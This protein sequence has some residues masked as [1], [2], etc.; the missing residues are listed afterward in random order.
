MMVILFDLDGVLLQPHAY[1]QALRDTVDF[2]G[3]AIGYRSVVLTKDDIELFESVGV[4]T[5]W[6]SSAICAALLLR[7]MWSIHPERRLPSAPPLPPAP[8]HDISAPQFQDFFRSLE[9]SLAADTSPVVAAERALLNDGFAYTDLQAFA[10][11]NILRGAHKPHGSLTHRLFQELVLG[12]RVFEETYNLEPYLDVAGLLTYLDEPMLTPDLRQQLLAWL[13]QPGRHAAVF[14]NRPSRPS[15]RTQ[16]APEAEMGLAALGLEVLPM[17]ARGGL[18][19]LAEARGL[20]ADTLLKPS[21]VHALAALLHAVGHPLEGALQAAA[22]LALDGIGDPVWNEFAGAEICVFEDSAA[23]L[24]SVL[25]A[26]ACLA[27]IG[28]EVDTILV[29]VTHS[30]DKKRSLEVAGG[31][32]FPEMSRAFQ[33]AGLF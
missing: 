4:T 15:L 3:K 26:Q 10:L 6:D 32:V 28:N 29:G 30:S 25:S 19:W 16:G 11:K 24:R 8:A 22:A 23:G 18:A 27:R 2:V 13:K 17:V 14:T 9:V 21:A 31:E 20:A 33:A 5:E 7:G 1:H 12:S